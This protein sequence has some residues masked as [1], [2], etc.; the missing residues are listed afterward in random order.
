MNQCISSETVS[1]L[2]LKNSA[3]ELVGV[4]LRINKHWV[5]YSVEE[6]NDEMISHLF[7]MN[8]A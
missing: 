5:F 8:H 2:A 3:G 4:V 7:S 1:C 6:M